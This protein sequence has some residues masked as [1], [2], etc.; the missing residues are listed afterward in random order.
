[1][2]FT[3]IGTKKTT[4]LKNPI[5]ID[6]SLKHLLAELGR[7]DIL[8]QR[9]IQHWQQAGQD[10][11]DAFRGLYISD[12]EAH[13]LMSRPVTSNWGELFP[14]LA[15][16]GQSESWDR[17]LKEAA[18]QARALAEAARN[19]GH[20]PRLVRLAETFGLQ[21]FDVDVLLICLAPHV[22]LRYER[23]FGY[24]QDDVTKKLPTTNLVLDLLCPPGPDRMANLARFSNQ[25]PLFTHRLLERPSEDL[26]TTLLAQVLS[27]DRTVA[28][29]LLGDYQPVWSTA[30]Q[31]FMSVP[32]SVEGDELVAGELE[33]NL[34]KAIE[35][36][37]ILA[38]YGPDGTAQR[39]AARL[40]ATKAK[41][42]LLEVSFQADAAGELPPQTALELAL[43]DAR[44]T[45]ALPFL[46]GWEATLDDYTLSPAAFA[47]LCA[48]PHLLMFS[49]AVRWLPKGYRHDRRVFW[50]E[51]PIPSYSRR[52]ALWGHFIEDVEPP[53][54]L[55]DVAGQFQ[56]TAGQIRDAVASAR[57]TAAQFARKLELGDLLAAARSHSNPRLGSLALKI[58]PHYDWKD[59]ILPDD[60]LS[61]L[62]ELVATVRERPLVLDEWGV[63]QKLV[64]NR[65]VTVLFAG[66]P[67][68]GKTMAAEIIAA[69]LG[70]DIFKI[71][72]STIV[73]K[74]IG[75]TEKNLERIFQEA[76]TSNAILFFDEADALFGKR[77]EVRDSHDR[78]ANIEISYLLQRMEAYNGVTIL[79]TNLRA[80]LD[81]A[82]TRRLQFA[83]DFPFP[84]EADRLR[85]WQTLFPPGVPIAPDLDFKLLARRFKLAGGNIRNVIVS[86][87]Y[88]AAS[89]G[90]VVTMTHML[91]A[92]RRE[93]QKMGRLVNQNDMDS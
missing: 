36:K 53:L 13:A 88:L 84:E 81:D 25:A 86:A 8:L 92:T 58:N 3:Y 68:T 46:R 38:F 28:A 65:G 63:G 37:P 35:Q 66:P 55:D 79:A 61:L 29:W 19:Q 6:L 16:D 22:D 9:Q 78:Y 74:Y 71:D 18:L 72:L 32:E 83:V 44:L 40:I 17:A 69:E 52:L 24:L 23:I 73:S 1:M 56:L 91:H 70:L 62:R 89:N 82:F 2:Q 39:A 21:A 45:G 30:V 31:F 75:E 42:P 64:P 26:K 12:Q 10:P 50:M 48:F 49:T 93:L 59:I 77:S 41:R 7:I 43:R 76:E 4:R 54:D 90:G 27:I 47:E 20:P 51:F 60:Q 34:E 80:N 11:N 57:N 14:G 87:A 5:E 67:G 15:N 33:L 85:I